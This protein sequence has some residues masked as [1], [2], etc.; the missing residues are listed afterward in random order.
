LSALLESLGLINCIK[1][2]HGLMD[3]HWIQNYKLQWYNYSGKRGRGLE[4]TEICY[5][6]LQDVT[7]YMPPSAWTISFRTESH[8]P[9]GKLGDLVIIELSR[10]EWAIYPHT[11]SS[12]DADSNLIPEP[13]SIDFVGEVDRIKGLCLRRLGNWPSKRPRR[14]A[15]HCQRVHHHDQV[16]CCF[17]KTQYRREMPRQPKLQQQ[18]HQPQDLQ[19]SRH[20]RLL[21]KTLRKSVLLWLETQVV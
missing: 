20:R 13:R 18:M 4:T 5:V 7:F 8:L 1:N 3:N 19:T 11:V 9:Y 10:P 14:D 12:L 6:S 2:P 21:P 15:R 16:C 17:A